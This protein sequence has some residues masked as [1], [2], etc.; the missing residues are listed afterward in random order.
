MGRST[1]QRFEIFR[2]YRSRTGKFVVHVERSAQ[3]TSDSEKWTTGW[4]AWVG[5][6]SSDQAW[7][8]TAPESILHIA[9][10]L[11]ELRDLLPRSSTRWS[12]TWPTSPSSKTSTS[13][14]RRRLG[15]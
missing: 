11:E 14:P 8:V 1:S 12:P 9:G 10:T 6:W 4:R 3:L 13:D 15:G 2:V 5:N 7:G